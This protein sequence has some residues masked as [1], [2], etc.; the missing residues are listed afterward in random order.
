MSLV[1]RGHAL[2]QQQ[3]DALV[4]VINANMQGYFSIKKFIAACDEALEA[5]GCPVPEGEGPCQKPT[6]KKRS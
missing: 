4:P 5:A 2:T 1:H 3:C 6:K